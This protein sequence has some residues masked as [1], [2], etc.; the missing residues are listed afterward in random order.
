MASTLVGGVPVADAADPGGALVTGYGHVQYGR[1]LFGAGSAARVR[2]LIGWR[3]L[4]DVELSDTPRPQAHGAYP[5]DALGDSLTITLVYQVRGTPEAKVAAIDAL[6]QHTPLDGVERMLCVEDTGL[7]GWYRMARVVARQIPQDKGYRHGPVECSVQFACADPRRY[8]LTERVGTVNLPA[9]TVDGLDYALTYPLEYGVASS[10]ALS[11]VNDG[12]AYAPLVVTFAGPLTNPQLSSPD[13]R[14]G[15]DL[16]L[17]AGESLV[18]DTATGTALLGGTADRMY[19]IRPTSDPLELCTIPP[20]GTTLTL[21]AASGT[22]N[23]TV[24]HRDA[25]L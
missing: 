16:N 3:D 12:G 11:V 19:A 4:P 5:G 24:T 10:T 14:L 22:G 9:A 25:R 1:V 20:G 15:F 21:T 18:V 6:E 8:S 17:V 2:Q 23:A 7:G 13:W